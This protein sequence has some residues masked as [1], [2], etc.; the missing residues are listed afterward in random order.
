MLG[1][2]CIKM[3]SQKKMKKCYVL[4]TYTKENIFKRLSYNS[5]GNG[6]C[7]FKLLCP[8]FRFKMLFGQLALF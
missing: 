4:R 7:C 2:Y 5:L 8:E 3:F 1:D 6:V